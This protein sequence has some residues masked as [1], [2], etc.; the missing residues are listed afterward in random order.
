MNCMMV[1][2]YRI[3]VTKYPRSSGVVEVFKQFQYYSRGIF[4]F[5]TDAMGATAILENRLLAPAISVHFSTV[6][7][8][9][10]C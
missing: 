4:L 3:I 2:T 8:N 10:G 5:S 6:G 7:K 9:C 1:L